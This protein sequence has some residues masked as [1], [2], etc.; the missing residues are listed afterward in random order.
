MDY[1]LPQQESVPL[2]LQSEILVVG[3]N[4]LYTL[5]NKVNYL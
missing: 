1:F 5:F 3:A 2:H 4:S